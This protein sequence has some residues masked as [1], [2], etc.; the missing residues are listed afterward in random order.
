MNALTRPLPPR[1]RA[2]L[3][4]DPAAQD[5]TITRAPSTTSCRLGDPAWCDVDHL[6]ETPIIFTPARHVAAVQVAP[7]PHAGPSALLVDVE[8][9]EAGDPTD[10]L[11]G[12]G[13]WHQYLC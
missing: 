2:R 6:G 10:V 12:A 3:E 8:E 7:G 13:V 1:V 5:V 4:G 9:T 11:D